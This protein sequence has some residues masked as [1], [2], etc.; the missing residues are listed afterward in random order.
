MSETVIPLYQMSN[1]NPMAMTYDR[2]S[3]RAFT[4]LLQSADGRKHGHITFDFLGD[5][6]W[7]NLNA[8]QQLD[9]WNFFVS[10]ANA[11]FRVNAVY[12]RQPSDRS[13]RFQSTTLGVMR[14]QMRQRLQN[15]YGHVVSFDCTRDPTVDSF[16]SE[17]NWDVAQVVGL[18]SPDC[19][20]QTYYLI[21][22]TG[23]KQRECKFTI[24][25]PNW[26]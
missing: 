2:H 14:A 10:F 15:L 16:H 25:D 20:K 19:V 22:A 13:V 21:P 3:G 7:S 24:T 4:A 12:A 9:F 17:L 8:E 26:P 23:W 6:L 18:V 11:P 1:A 5:G